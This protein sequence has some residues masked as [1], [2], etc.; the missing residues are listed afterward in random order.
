MSPH[1]RVPVTA[2]AGPAGARGI[3][4]I[5]RVTVTVAVSDGSTIT[6]DIPKPLNAGLDYRAE[7]GRCAHNIGVLGYAA[8]VPCGCQ[9]EQELVLAVELNPWRADGEPVYTVTTQQTPERGSP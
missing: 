9:D 2:L 4:A 6:L 1:N 5:D 7:H 3:P 8:R